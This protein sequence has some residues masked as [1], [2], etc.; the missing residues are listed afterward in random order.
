MCRD[1]LTRDESAGGHF[2]EEHEDQG[3]ALRNDKDFAHAAVWEYKGKDEAPK[4]HEEP[5][6]FEHVKLATRNYE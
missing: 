6:T 5:L 3:E 1:A 4:R 2:R